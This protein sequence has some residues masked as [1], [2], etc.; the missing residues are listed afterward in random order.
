MSTKN[1]YGNRKVVKAVYYEPESVFQIPD[2]LDLED[3]SVVSEWYVKWDILNIIYADGKV[4]EIEAIDAFCASSDD[5]DYKRPIKAKILSVD[6]IHS[7][8]CIYEVEDE[9]YETA[10]NTAFNIAINKVKRSKIYN[11]GL[12]LKLN[13]KSAGIT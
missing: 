10:F 7:G 13:M 1:V 2:G 6:E 4:E 5:Y 12:G 3:K 8:D 9:K 11:Y